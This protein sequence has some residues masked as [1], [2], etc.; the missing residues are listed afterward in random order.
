MPPT[1]SAPSHLAPQRG[2]GGPGDPA[3][4]G[5]GTGGRPL[6]NQRLTALVGT[7]LLVLFAAQG[8]TILSVSRLL[9]WH[10]IFGL[11]LIGPATLKLGT[12]CYRA[13]R[14][15]T[16]AAAYRH[17]G[18]PPPALRLLGPAV[19]VTTA[20]VLATGTTLA[21]TGER[22]VDGLPV[23]FLHKAFFY[24]WLA[25]MGLHVLVHLWRLPRLI[26]ADLRR[27]PSGRA[28]VGTGHR[29]AA[30]RAAEHVPGRALRWL[31]P[32]L[33]LAVGIGLA[34]AGAPLASRWGN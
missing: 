7:L 30:R 24:L 21:L 8:V 17:Q 10:F 11:T 27:R 25:A 29:A 2:P 1:S 16:G 28:A 22:T 4:P 32:V 15:Y 20:G 31:L 12:V 33:A 34:I 18:P 3:A 13:V 23:L 19:V 14:Y 26:G 6:G 9:T 5:A